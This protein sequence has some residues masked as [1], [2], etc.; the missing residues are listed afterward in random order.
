VLKLRTASAGFFS[1]NETRIKQI[2]SSDLNDYFLQQNRLL[3]FGASHLSAFLKVVNFKL[4]IT[5]V[6]NWIGYVYFLSKKSITELANMYKSQKQLQAEMELAGGKK[7]DDETAW[8]NYFTYCDE[9]P[10]FRALPMREIWDC[11]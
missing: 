11:G 7:L 8:D 10:S 3:C 4:N 2:G 1:Q 5:P 9:R 6:K